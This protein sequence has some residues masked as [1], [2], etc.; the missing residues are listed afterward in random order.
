MNSDRASPRLM[1][2]T[3][4]LWSD[5]KLRFALLAASRG[6]SEGAL[7][8][9]ILRDALALEETSPPELA[10]P[11]HRE[12][13]TD[14]ITVRLRPGDGAALNARAAGQGLHLPGS[15]G[16][17][18]YRC[19]CGSHDRGAPRHQA[20]HHPADG[21]RANPFSHDPLLRSRRLHSARTA[22]SP[23]ADPHNPGHGGR[24]H[25]QA[26]AGGTQELGVAL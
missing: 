3:V 24:S 21:Y 16:A 23:G 22:P 26:G 19:R 15:P 25:L 12:W 7:A 1:A 14:R 9:K 11:P 13:A 6:L 8:L 2:I 4:R 17:L 18:P 10:K 20:V 5:E